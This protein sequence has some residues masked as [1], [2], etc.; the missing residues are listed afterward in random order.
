M[1][2]NPIARDQQEEA[3]R[4][5][6]EEIREGWEEATGP[7]MSDADLILQ[8]HLIHWRLRLRSPATVAEKRAWH[9]VQ[10]QLR[11]RF[12]G[13]P[14]PTHTSSWSVSGIVT[15][16]KPVSSEVRFSPDSRFY[17]SHVRSRAQT[18]RLD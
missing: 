13:Q 15:S 4:R 11:R 16:Q 18:F 12:P 8:M 1:A 9:R 7:L 2:V 17:E 6:T 5:A 14:M 10:A 3:Q